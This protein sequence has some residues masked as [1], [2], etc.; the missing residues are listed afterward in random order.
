M[1]NQYPSRDLVWQPDDGADWNDQTL[2]DLAIR[3]VILSHVNEVVPNARSSPI[4]LPIANDTSTNDELD[5]F[6]N[7][8]AAS[9]DLKRP[10][11]TLI[12]PDIRRS[13]NMTCKRQY[14]NCS[15]MKLRLSC[16]STIGS[17]TGHRIPR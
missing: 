2:F 9:L 8:A 11:K 15:L 3:P 4:T 10:P 1:M 5:G 6:K 16:L 17:L 14:E 7:V 12:T 13:S